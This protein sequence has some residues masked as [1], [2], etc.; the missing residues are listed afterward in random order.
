MCPASPQSITRCAKLIPAPAMLERPLTSTTGLTVP[1]WIPMRT[2]SSGWLR[3]ALLISNA[4]ETGVSGGVAK[5][6]VIR[7]P[8][9]FIERMQI[10]A[11]RVD[12]ELGGTDNIDE[13]D[14]PD[15]EPV[16][17]LGFGGHSGR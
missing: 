10:I 9:N 3:S 1:L 16:L 4:Q 2:C 5:T 6:S 7:S 11:L 17:F 8:N 12:Q 14:V 15:L 13:A